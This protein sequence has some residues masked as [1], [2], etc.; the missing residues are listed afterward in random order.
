LVD[1]LFSLGP[2]RR[3]N[4]HEYSPFPRA[5]TPFCF[6]R[7]SRRA[8]LF[9]FFCALLLL[10]FHPNAVAFVRALCSPSLSSLQ[11][12]ELLSLGYSRCHRR[13]ALSRLMNT[14]LFSVFSL[15]SRSPV[16]YSAL[17]TPSHPIQQRRRQLTLLLPLPSYRLPFSRRLHSMS[18][19]TIAPSTQQAPTRLRPPLTLDL[20]HC[21]SQASG[22][23]SE[24]STTAD[25]SRAEGVEQRKP[26]P[27]L[28]EAVRAYKREPFAIF[29]PFPPCRRP[30]AP[31][32]STLRSLN[33]PLRLFLG[34]H[35]Y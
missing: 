12:D 18:L 34:R 27:D 19:V 15:T 14:P 26:P 23:G 35:Q 4:I 11:T 20:A 30:S 7:E 3:R 28:D 22:S 17:A 33:S 8:A 9:C 25:S 5:P 29:F 6:R 16:Y 13:L 21:G 31:D 2:R 10:C 24:A 1:S 32:P